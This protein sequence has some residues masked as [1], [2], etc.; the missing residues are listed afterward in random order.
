MRVSNQLNISWDTCMGSWFGYCAAAGADAAGAAAAGADAAVS[1]PAA[2]PP[3][4]HRQPRIDFRRPWRRSSTA[5]STGRSRT[6]RP[7]R[8]PTRRAT[9]RVRRREEAREAAVRR[10]GLQRAGHRLCGLQQR[11]EAHVGDPDKHA[12]CWG[13]RGRRATAAVFWRGGN[14]R[15]LARARL[16][17][18][19]AGTL[20]T[21]RQATKP[22]ARKN[23]RAKKPS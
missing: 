12:G 16:Q 13:R 19:C 23:R 6:G 17:W 3:S 14:E 21:C 18:C 5:S 10:P 8:L 4:P 2:A 11:S 9:Y 15:L 1:P 7:R 20:K 22:G